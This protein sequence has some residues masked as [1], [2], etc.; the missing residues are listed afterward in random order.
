MLSLSTLL[1]HPQNLHDPAVVDAWFTRIA[2]WLL[3]PCRLEVAGK[4]HRLVEV[5]LYFNSPEHPDPFAH[6]HLEQ[7]VR[8]H[9]YF[10]RVGA[11]YRGGSFKGV[12]LTFGG[13]EARGGILIRSIEAPG[14]HFVVGPSLCVDHLIAETG[15][16]SV[17]ELARAIGNRPVWDSSSQVHLIDGAETTVEMF[18]SAR[19]GLTLKRHTG[20]VAV[21][22]LE[23]PYRFLSEPRAVTKGRAELISALLAEGRSPEE[24]RRLTGSPLKSILACAQ[25]SARRGRIFSRSCG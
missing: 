4:T 9:W 24:I 20:A 2:A 18:R 15:M 10:H 3:G 8:G 17:A 23:R 13:G 16:S 5:E 25:R 19:V 21:D 22:R 11:S 14:G 1:A 7:A 12:D 6:C